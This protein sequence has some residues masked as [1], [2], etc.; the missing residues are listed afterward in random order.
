MPALATPIMR[1]VLVLQWKQLTT[2][3][4]TM[5]LTRTNDISEAAACLQPDDELAN[6][7]LRHTRQSINSPMEQVYCCACCVA[8]FKQEGQTFFH[9]P[10]C[11]SVCFPLDSWFVFFW[12][13]KTRLNCDFPRG[14]KN[15]NPE[16]DSKKRRGGGILVI[17]LKGCIWNLHPSKLEVIH[18]F[19]QWR[20]IHAAARAAVIPPSSVSTVGKVLAAPRAVLW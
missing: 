15:W 5:D 11:S 20:V 13:K 6:V 4:S 18:W 14:K 10:W 12:R 3:V 17:L 9:C 16:K 7:E 2:T 19:S 1:R 8:S